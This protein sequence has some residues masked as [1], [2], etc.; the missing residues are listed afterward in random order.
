MFLELRDYY[1]NAVRLHVTAADALVRRG[2]DRTTSDNRLIGAP[3]Q[4][5]PIFTEPVQ[6]GIICAAEGCGRHPFEACQNDCYGHSNDCDDGRPFSPQLM[7]GTG[8]QVNQVTDGQG[9][10]SAIKILADGSGDDWL[11]RRLC[12]CWRPPY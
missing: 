6:N 9:M 7:T 12:A 5:L 11:T 1:V 4:H 2:V 10:I 8:F 3:G